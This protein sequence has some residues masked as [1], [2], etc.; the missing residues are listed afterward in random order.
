M[1]IS[2]KSVMTL[3][4]CLSAMVTGA[5]RAADTS[6]P[7]GG[8]LLKNSTFDNGRSIPWTDSFTSP[9]SGKTFIRD[10][11]YCL[12]IDNPG[13]NRW[14]AQ[15]RHREMVIQKGHTYYVKYRAWATRKT[16]MRPKVGMAGPPY[17]EYWHKTV[18][19]D[20]EPRTFEASFTMKDEDD[21]TA[22][23]TFHAGGEMAVAET[24]FTIC[25]D[26]IYLTDKQFTPPQQEQKI[27]IPNIR[28]NQLGYL[29]KRRKL[30]VIV[31][32]GT[33]P[34]R[35]ELKD[36]ANS[37]VVS[38]MTTIYGNDVESGD[39]L[40]IADF[41]SFSKE[42][43]G[44]KLV[45][46]GMQS[47][48]F[49]ISNN[50]YRQIKYDALN[51]FYHNRS[52]IEIKMPYARQT[53]WYRPAGHAPD[54]A[55]AT[56]TEILKKS[57]W[58]TK[59]YNYKLDVT[60]GWYDAG[61]HGK[62]V[63]NGGISVWTMMNQYERF[64]SSG[65]TIDDFGDGK[66]TIPE[67]GN[68]IPDILD[69]ARWQ[70]E[71]MLKMQAPDN[72]EYAGMVH[73]K[74]HDIAWTALGL[75]PFA[76]KQ[77]RVFRPVTTA[78][79]LNLA[80][81]AAQA[82]RIYKV[83]DKEFSQKNL[84]AAIKA[85]EAAKKHPAMFAPEQ[86]NQDGG[87]PYND[88]YVQDEFYWAAVELFVTTG[89][90]RYYNDLKEN[91]HHRK[92]KNETGY[93]SAMD[94]SMTDTLGAIT[95]AS[96]ESKL[97]QEDVDFQRNRIISLA[98]KYAAADNKKRGYAAPFSV[99]D[100]KYPWG[101]NSF[102]VNNMIILAYAHDFTMDESFL[103]T[104]SSGMDYIL[105]R[106]AMG[107]SYIT[108]YGERPLKNPHHR[109]WAKQANADFPPPPPGALSGG[110]NSGLEDPYV[111]AAGLKGCPPQ[112]CFIDHIEAW[113][114]NEITINWNAPLAW[115]TAYLDENG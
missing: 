79:T 81:T 39:H 36:S 24:P 11:T 38:G 20:A 86:D 82:A 27:V 44:Y 66:L 5:V 46:E 60:G 35:W 109:F 43:Q 51:Y 15:I 68:G 99:T 12:Q 41:S 72:T 10:K 26:D 64:L 14:D 93:A 92:L 16:K 62:Y 87:G 2:L 42:G 48:A 74:I 104:M 59:Q 113:S 98:R 83:F 69:E 71:F 76:D 102:I 97:T 111:K 65:K 107:Q 106:N 7:P 37:T 1:L 29:P 40:H 17:T 54:I 85:Y 73:H 100:N 9:G 13:K 103:D 49:E 94:W 8:N 3:A 114:V 53:T 115:V 23:F 55:N 21:A 57:G 91:P 63:V 75:S 25:F 105:G 22:E 52:G 96:V 88:D 6:P 19:I 47:D 84:A 89:E 108:G 110:P 70:M 56:P 80:A 50:I 45:A 61:D 58:P 95:L 90:I 77:Q 78:A 67:S 34:I 33:N 112:K 31:N 101:S 4:I 28:L 32:T 18:E 30:A